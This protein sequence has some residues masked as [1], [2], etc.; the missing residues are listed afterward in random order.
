MKINDLKERLGIYDIAVNDEQLNLLSSFMEETLSTNEKFNLTA[1]VDRDVFVEK[2]IFDS[3]MALRELDLTDKSIIDIGT[4]AGYPGMVLKILAPS[5]NVSLLDSTNKK[6][7]YLANFAKNN[8][9][10]VN[11]ICDRSEHYAK[12]HREKYDYAIARAVASLDVLLEIISPLLK[13][14]GTLIAMKG[15]DYEKEINDSINAFKKL[16]L[17]ID[18]IYEFELPESKEKRVLIYIRKVKETNKKYP[19]EFNEIKRQPL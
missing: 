13:V 11:T 14:N 1:I 16:N 12:E 5:A 8:N 6:I 10:K 15:A 9:L 2:M 19:R 18:S 7:D 3:A 17:K 4:G